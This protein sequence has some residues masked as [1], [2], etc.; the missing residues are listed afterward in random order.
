V[1][2]NVVAVCGLRTYHFHVKIIQEPWEPQSTLNPKG[3][4]CP[5]MAHIDLVVCAATEQPVTV[6]VV[7]KI[8]G[9][10]QVECSCT[11]EIT[12][13]LSHSDN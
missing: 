3:L 9:L 12:T 7:W 6:C 5:V 1:W 8:V 4:S 10:W 2:V 13:K 11:E